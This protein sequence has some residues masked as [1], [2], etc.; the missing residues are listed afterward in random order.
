MSQDR[1]PTL[2]PTKFETDRQCLYCQQNVPVGPKYGRKFMCH[3]CS[4]V[5]ERITSLRR[6]LA[7][8][9]DLYLFWSELHSMAEQQRNETILY[10]MDLLR[11]PLEAYRKEHLRL[12]LELESRKRVR[13]NTLPYYRNCSQCGLSIPLG[14]RTVA[15]TYCHACS[16][17][18]EAFP[19]VNK[20][21]TELKQLLFLWNDLMRMTE[22]QRRE[23]ILRQMTLLQEALDVYAEELTH[24]QGELMRRRAQRPLFGKESAHE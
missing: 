12:L 1:P 6:R 14:P 22:A 16:L 20:Y 5:L 10:Q 23:E 2:F 17:L 13:V 21:Y 11:E 7:E 24:L 9:Q 4:L 18:A 8:H 3:R 19:P 15:N